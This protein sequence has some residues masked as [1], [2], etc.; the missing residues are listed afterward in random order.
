MSRATGSILDE[1]T[2]TFSARLFLLACFT[3]NACGILSV[4]NGI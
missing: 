3:R 1:R 2:A 4:K